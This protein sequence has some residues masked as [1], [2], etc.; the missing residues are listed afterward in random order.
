MV[1]LWLNSMVH[2]RYITILHVFLPTN[3]TGG[4][5]LYKWE[6]SNAGKVIELIFLDI[7]L[8]SWCGLSMMGLAF[9]QW[10][11]HSKRGIYRE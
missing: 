2:V 10:E 6:V 7:Y 3:I 8:S 9:S 4:T 11:I 1:N 5:I